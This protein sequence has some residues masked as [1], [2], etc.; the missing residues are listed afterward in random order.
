MKQHMRRQWL[1]RAGDDPRLFTGPGIEAALARGWWDSP[2]RAIEQPAAD[3][4]PAHD[5]ETQ[6]RLG[7]L[8]LASEIGV[9][10]DGRWGIKRLRDAL[11]V[12]QPH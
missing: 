6:E 2:K 12:C 4:Q 10:V 1:Y 11:N 7:L 9:R 8:K 5:E 3:D